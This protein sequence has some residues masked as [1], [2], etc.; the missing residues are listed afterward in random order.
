MGSIYGAVLEEGRKVNPE[1]AQVL[2]SISSWWN[3]DSSHDFMHQNILLCQENLHSH[4]KVLLESQEIFKHPSSL[5]IVSDTRIDNRDELLKELNLSRDISNSELIL[6]LFLKY[7]HDCPSKLIGAF[8]FAIWD[9]SRK[10]LFCARD[11]MGVKPLNYYWRRD[12]FIF[13]TQK[14]CILSFDEVEKTPDWRNIM[15]CI[16]RIEVPPNSTHYLN[17]KIL[18]PAHY[19]I[20]ENGELKINR[21]WSLNTSKRTSFKNDADYVDYF[22]EIFSRAIAD[23]MDVNGI[24]GTHL[25][26]GLDSSG[27]SGFVHQHS[28]KHDSQSLYYSYNVEKKYLEDQKAFR[29]NA[30][31][32][33]FIKYHNIESQF[34]NVHKHVLRPYDKMIEDETQSCDGLSRSNNV[35]TE[36]EMQHAAKQHGTKVILSGFPGDELITSFCRPYYLEY[37][38]EGKW[39]KYFTKKMNSR[40]GNK[41]KFKAFGGALIASLNNNLANHIGSYYNEKRTINSQYV[42]TSNFLNKAYFDDDSLF[43]DIKKVKHY[44]NVHNGFPTSLR[45]YQKNHVCRPHTSRRIESE[46]LAGL[47]WGLEYRYPMAD[48]RVLQ[49]VLSIPMEQKITPDMSRSIFRRSAKGYMPDSIRLRDVKNAGSLKP[50]VQIYKRNFRGSAWNLWQKYEKEHSAPFLNPKA[51]KIQLNTKEKSPMGIFNWL[52]FAQLGFE[53]KLDF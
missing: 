26:G 6:E 42:G 25:S 50:M 20:F 16:S 8:S 30:L 45:E 53:K 46:N 5:K 49:Y 15:N 7:R 23:R 9:V 27:I 21:Y 43:A 32:Y 33:D 41:E 19:L 4:D 34:I 24:L 22:K 10:Y 47:R 37:F 31:A 3:P 29:E 13:S 14:K 17:I 52:V 1:M 11:Q 2:S 44:S 12:F 36:Y 48:I 28:K 40:H 39:F 18:P 35:N 38:S 51:I